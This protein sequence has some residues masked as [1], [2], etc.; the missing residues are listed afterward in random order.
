MFIDIHTY[1]YIYM[2]A[3]VY[4]VSRGARSFACW[5]AKASN[6]LETPQLET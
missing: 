6:P 1:I 4:C 5:N 3:Y 2:C